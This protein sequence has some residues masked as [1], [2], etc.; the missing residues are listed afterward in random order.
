MNKNMKHGRSI[1]LEHFKRKLKEEQDR[2]EKELKD[3]ARINPE[4]PDDWEPT[5]ADLNV[6]Q[7]DKNEVADS[8]AAYEGDSAVEVE[9]EN[10]LYEVCKA[11]KRIDEGNYG[12][13]SAGGEPIPLDRL[14]VN[15]AADRC[16]EHM[17][18]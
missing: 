8:M 12:T 4:N 9:L 10:R 16:I 15:P 7:S 17:Q 13:C 1:D 2:L 14:E 6:L 18:A 3:V 5:A 11:L